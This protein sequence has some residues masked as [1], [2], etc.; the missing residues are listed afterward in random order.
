MKFSPAPAACK[1]LPKAPLVPLLELH[2]QVSPLRP[3]RQLLALS[4]RLNSLRLARQEK[5]RPHLRLRPLRHRAPRQHH[6]S[7]PL[8]RR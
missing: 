7:S 4:P 3:A 2:L 1:Y 8:P 5:K 6:Q